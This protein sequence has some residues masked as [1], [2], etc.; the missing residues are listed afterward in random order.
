MR[1]YRAWH[2]HNKEYL[3]NIG[4]IDFAKKVVYVESGGAFSFDDVVLEQ[5]V[6]KKDKD[7]VEIHEG[8]VVLLFADAIEHNLLYK[9]EWDTYSLSYHLRPLESSRYGIIYLRVLTEVDLKIV[10]SIHEN[11]EISLWLN[12]NF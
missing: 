3:V 6:G 10:G 7:G 1:L 4:V 9:V 5:Q 12:N 2:K 11:K 8:D